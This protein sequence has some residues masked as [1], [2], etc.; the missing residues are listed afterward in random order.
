M[1]K[2][3][4]IRIIVLGLITL[5]ALS[6]CSNNSSD[7]AEILKRRIDKCEM[8]EYVD[9]FYGARLLYPDFFKIDSVGKCYASFSYSDE[10]IK[11]LNLFYLIYPP[12]IIE[13]PKEYARN[14]TDSLTT[15]SRVKS[16]SFILTEEY[17]FFPETKS[18]YKFYKTKHG[19]TSYILT[20]EKEYEDAV[21]KLVDMVKDWKIYSEDYPEWVTDLFDFLDF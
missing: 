2:K 14:K 7:P 8:V 4:I 19:W 10:N 5:G 6:S 12:R 13:N 18:I 9:S 3:I 21:E 17:E 16:S 20:Y 11:E 1:R 15:F